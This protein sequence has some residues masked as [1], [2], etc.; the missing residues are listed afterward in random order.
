MWVPRKGEARVGFGARQLQAER[1]HRKGRAMVRRGAIGLQILWLVSG[2]VSGGGCAHSP[3]GDEAATGGAGQD[4]PVPAESE[5][6][7]APHAKITATT[8]VGTI[9]VAAGKGLQRCYTW[10]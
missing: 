4:D 5:I 10:D 7:M 6:V 8:E 9:I 2:V 3:R 1:Q